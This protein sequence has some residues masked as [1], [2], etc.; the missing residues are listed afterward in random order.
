MKKTPVKIKI[1]DVA[2][3][4]E[5]AQKMNTTKFLRTFELDSQNTIFFLA[6]L[7]IAKLEKT[8]RMLNEWDIAMLNKGELIWPKKK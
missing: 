6:R 5:I 4:V 7:T 1:N 8:D 2:L 3:L